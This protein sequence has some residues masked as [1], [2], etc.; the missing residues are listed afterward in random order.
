MHP[1]ILPMQKKTPEINGCVFGA[2]CKAELIIRV[3]IIMK[4]T[5]MYPHR[6]LKKTPIMN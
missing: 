1:N 3:I 4:A 2:M 5:T 6:A